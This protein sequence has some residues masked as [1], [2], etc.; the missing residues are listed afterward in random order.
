MPGGDVD[1]LTK[2]LKDGS[3]QKKKNATVKVLEATIKCEGNPT[4]KLNEVI[5]VSNVA[6][7]YQGNW[8]V[9]GVENTIAASSAY[10]TNL[11][12]SKNGTSKSTKDDNGKE[13][14]VAGKVNKSKGGSKS[15]GTK[16]VK[17]VR[18]D[19]NGN[20]KK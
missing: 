8:Y 14:K 15:E 16:E 19:Q 6:K 9:V 12:L 7:R 5:T 11:K 4:I 1:S 18:Y 10:F 17:V 3:S 13:S 20:P 2:N